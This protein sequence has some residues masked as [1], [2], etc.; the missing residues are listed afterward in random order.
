MASSETGP[1]TSHLGY[2]ESIALL[3]TYI[4]AKVFTSCPSQMVYLGSTSGWITNLVAAGTASLG[5]LAMY[6][7]VSRFRGR[8]FQKCLEMTVGK[9]PGKVLGALYVLFLAGVEAISIR[10]FASGFKVAILPETPLMAISFLSFAFLA[11]T[12]SLGIEALGR[13]AALAFAP[14]GFLFLLILLVSGSTE[15][16]LAQIYPLWGVGIRHTL[17]GGIPCA[18]LY[19]E[20][21]AFGIVFPYIRENA[22]GERLKVGLFSLW[23]AAAA[24]TAVIFTSTAVFTASVTAQTLFPVLQLA[25]MFVVG[26]F[27]ER[28]EAIFV[29]AWLFFAAV[30]SALGLSLGAILLA[31]V[32][33]VR[34]WKLFVFPVGLMVLTLSLLPRT[35]VDV[36]I[37]QVTAFRS[38]GWI[39]AFVVP[40]ILL[41]IAALRRVPDAGGTAKARRGQSPI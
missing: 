18:S 32:L 9:A 23:V 36:F 30:K 25:R 37:L 31:D 8:S 40:A 6:H 33:G 10:E 27:L 5:V 1:V 17:A 34:R 12:A 26:A 29:A 39:A 3:A 41:V 35:L 15:F 24:M 7:F 16:D 19:T 14:L 20:A 13:F 22:P 38:V 11:W 2:R 4:G 28:V 21:F